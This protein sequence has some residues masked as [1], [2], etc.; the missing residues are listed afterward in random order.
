LVRGRA[1]QIAEL[2]HTIRQ[3]KGVL[4]GELSLASVGRVL[5]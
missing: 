3:L 1:S 5:R 4:K 2:G